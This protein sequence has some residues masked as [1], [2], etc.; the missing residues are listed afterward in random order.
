MN[1]V[2]RKSIKIDVKFEDIWIN[3]VGI[4]NAQL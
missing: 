3:M 1:Y 4:T 2:I